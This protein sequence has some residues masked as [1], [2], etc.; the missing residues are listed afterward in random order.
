MQ[1]TFEKMGMELHF[2]MWNEIILE[3]QTPNSGKYMMRKPERA[4]QLR[5]KSACNIASTRQLNGKRKG[6]RE[7]ERE[8]E[9][10]YELSTAVAALFR[11]GFPIPSYTGTHACH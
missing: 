6:E 5:D 10:S 4:S 7:R 2:V 11:T 8:R 1:I 9:R 3:Q